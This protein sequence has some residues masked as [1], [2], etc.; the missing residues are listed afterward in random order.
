MVMTPMLILMAKR[1][2]PGQTKTRLC[3]PLTPE[4]AARLYAGMLRDSI[5]LI[6]QVPAVQPAI[7][8]SPD[9]AE[10]YFA[11]LAPDLRLLRQGSGD[12]AQRLAYV[13]ATAFAYGAPAVAVMSSDTPMLPLAY[14]QQAFA[15]LTTH[16]LVLGPCDDGGYYLAALRR[17][18]PSIFTSVTMSTPHVLR[19]TMAEAQRLGLSVSLL[20]SCYDIDTPADLARLAADPVPLLHTR[21]ALRSD[22]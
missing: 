16:E 3:P 22:A 2:S 1:P 6:Q 17:P 7:A 5:A 13:T 14:L 21:A 15:A 9:D 18:A 8:V 20:P 12:L 19:D 10:G 11:D 4:Q